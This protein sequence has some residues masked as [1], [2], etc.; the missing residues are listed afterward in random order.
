MPGSIP[1]NVQSRAENPPTRL[2]KK[3]PMRL[4]QPGSVGLARCGLN[5]SEDDHTFRKNAQYRASLSLHMS[6]TVPFRFVS[7]H[8][9]SPSS[10]ACNAAGYLKHDFLKQEVAACIRLAM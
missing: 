8:R 6:C 1:Q 5:R 7:F 3:H 9:R 2:A 4:N 10:S